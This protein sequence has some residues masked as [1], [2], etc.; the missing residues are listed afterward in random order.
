MIDKKTKTIQQKKSV[1]LITEKRLQANRELLIGQKIKRLFPGH[2][3]VIG[4]VKKYSVSNDAY[5]LTYADGHHEWIPFLDIL[6]HLLR[7]WQRYEAKYIAN[8]LFHQVRLAALESEE[9]RNNP[10]RPKSTLYTEGH[11]DI[12]KVWDSPDGIFWKEDTDKVYYILEDKKKCWMKIKIKD[13]PRGKSLTDVR[14]VFKLKDK[15]G[16]FEKHRA[17]IVAKGHLQKRD[18]DY[19][20]S[21]APTA[22]HITIRLVIA[23]TAIPGFFSYDYDAVCAFIAHLY[24][25]QSES[26]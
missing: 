26:T 19:F 4:T 6:G 20:E 2:G 12:F 1:P 17:R 8:E 11:S 5:Y 13:I 22:S 10:T 9:V 7:S 3:D 18:I 25:Y 23:I 24:L 15:N 21:F 16:V 14:W